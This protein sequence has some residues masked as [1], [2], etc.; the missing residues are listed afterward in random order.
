MKMFEKLKCLLFGH[1]W[2]VNRKFFRKKE[3]HLTIAKSGDL[4]RWMDKNLSDG[5]TKRL[6]MQKCRRCGKTDRVDAIGVG[7]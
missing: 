4:A 5:E 2:N 7:E 1:N 3:E 6:T